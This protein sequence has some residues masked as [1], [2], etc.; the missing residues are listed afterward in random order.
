MLAIE[1]SF[2]LGFG[3]ETDLRD[4][5]GE[6]VVSHDPPTM[7]CKLRSLEELFSLHNSI[8]PELFLALNIKSD[9]LQDLILHEL[10][11]YPN[12]NYGLFDMSVP[13]LVKTKKAGLKFLSR[14]SELEP[15]APFECDAEGYWLD[16]FFEDWI[17]LTLLKNM[18][19][20]SKI[21]YVVSS[22]LHGREC[23]GN[24]DA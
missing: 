24:G 13:D 17:D 4:L 14:R 2:R 7:D 15:S 10:Q 22:E 16:E 1:K 6:V 9:G 8:N 11:K 20:T 12:A 23:Q 19:Q 5:N 3:V 21:V 18:L